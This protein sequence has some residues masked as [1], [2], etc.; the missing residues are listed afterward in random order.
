MMGAGARFYSFKGVLNSP[1]IIYN[2]IIDMSG[3]K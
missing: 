2:S 1:G 3:V